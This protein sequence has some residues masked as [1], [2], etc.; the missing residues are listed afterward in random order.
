MSIEEL[1]VAIMNSIPVYYSIDQVK[2]AFTSGRIHFLVS[3]KTN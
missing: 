2:E 1:R 3:K